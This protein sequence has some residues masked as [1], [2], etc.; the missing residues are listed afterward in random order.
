MKS[1][2]SLNKTAA[3]VKPNRN[4]I[5][6]RYNS[7]IC[8]IEALMNESTNETEKRKLSRIRLELLNLWDEYQ[9]QPARKTSKNI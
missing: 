5:D 9:L 6:T 1:E 7:A 8:D 3:S 4:V 2:I